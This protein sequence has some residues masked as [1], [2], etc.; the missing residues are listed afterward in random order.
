MTIRILRIVLKSPPVFIFFLTLP[1]ESGSDL[2]ALATHS[3]HFSVLLA[4]VG[5]RAFFSRLQDQVICLK[6]CP[7]ARS[8][9]RFSNPL[10]YARARGWRLPLS[11]HVGQTAMI[12]SNATPCQAF[13]MYSQG[14]AGLDPATND[15]Q[16]GLRTS[17]PMNAQLCKLKPQPAPRQSQVYGGA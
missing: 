11:C 7:R 8:N 6:T 5:C 2:L 14:F 4:V 10:R 16:I 1:A 3:L 9:S 12:F 17:L 13:S 15:R